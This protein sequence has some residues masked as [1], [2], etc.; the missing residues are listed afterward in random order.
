MILPTLNPAST[1]EAQILKARGGDAE[2]LSNLAVEAKGHWPYSQE[3]IERW[4][5]ELAVTSEEIDTG[6][7]FI[8]YRCERPVG[9]YLIDTKGHEARLEHLWVRPQAIGGGVGKSRLRH[10][11][12]Q[13][14]EKGFDTLEIDADPHAEPFYLACGARREGEIPA[15][16]EGKHNR[17]RPQLRIHNHAGAVQE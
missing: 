11:L 13:A 15:P 6:I 3:Q 16:I 1:D 17:V 4:R 2:M 10:A 9:F 5:P 7:A 12:Q 14:A 8:A